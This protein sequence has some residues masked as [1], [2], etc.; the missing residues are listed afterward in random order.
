MYMY[1]HTKVLFL[2]SF[3][4]QFLSQRFLLYLHSHQGSKST[5][6]SFQWRPPTRVLRHDATV[7][8]SSFE[9]KPEDFYMFAASY[10]SAQGQHLE[11]TGWDGHRIK[12]LTVLLIIYFI[13]K[14]AFVYSKIHVASYFHERFG[15]H[16]H[17]WC[18]VLRFFQ[19]S[20]WTKIVHNDL[21]A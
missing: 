15:H 14:A 8:S 12:Q 3:W 19:V 21:P 20:A 9:W 7:I 18:W 17:R 1:T 2:R 11:V 6:Q 4:I 13:Y 10:E 5:F 16:P